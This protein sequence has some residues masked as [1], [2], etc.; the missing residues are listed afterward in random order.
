MSS[1]LRNT[2]YP[3]SGMELLQLSELISR[4][5]SVGLIAYILGKSTNAIRLKAMQMDLHVQSGSQSTI[6]IKLTSIRV[7]SGQFFT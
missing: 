4:K 2:G 5:T 1:S 3:W 6:G 7:R